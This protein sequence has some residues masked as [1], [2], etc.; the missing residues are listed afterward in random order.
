MVS[1]KSFAAF[2]A[3]GVLSATAAP[4]NDLVEAR[5]IATRQ[6]TVSVYVC[7]HANWRGACKQYDSNPVDC[8][9]SKPT[10]TS[11]PL[12]K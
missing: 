5:A 10:P 4:A 12:K 2:L 6:N 9:E 7:E 1:L 11:K 8:G 3:L